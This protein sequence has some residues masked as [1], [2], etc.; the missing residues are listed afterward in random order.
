MLRLI[1]IFL[2]KKKKKEYVKSVEKDLEKDRLENFF[3]RDYEV[4]VS[5][6]IYHTCF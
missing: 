6:H 3:S 4:N 2:S 1:N 5:N